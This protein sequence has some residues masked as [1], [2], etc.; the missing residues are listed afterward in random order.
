MMETF[1]MLARKLEP[2]IVSE[3]IQRSISERKGDPLPP[4]S[5]KRKANNDSNRRTKTRQQKEILDKT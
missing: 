3:R 5:K 4:K 1:P 2:K